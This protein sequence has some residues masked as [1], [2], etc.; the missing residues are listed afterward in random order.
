MKPEKVSV[1]CPRC[2]HTQQE[3]KAAFSS[4]CRKCGQYL[5][6]ED[7]LRTAA[8]PK[9]DERRA[10]GPGLRRVTCFTCG[11]ELQVSSTAQSTM[12]KRCSAH[13]DLRDYRI[14][15]A[16]S[17]N[18][19]TKGRF[20]VEEGA[21]LFNSESMAGDMVLKGRFLGKLTVENSLEIHPKAEIKGAFKA[22]RLVIC[23]G[24]RF[25]WPQTLQL[26]GADIAGEMVAD[27][28]ATST[29]VL[30]STARMFG[31]VRAPKM[32]VESGA[33]FVGNARIQ[34][35]EAPQQPALPPEWVSTPKQDPQPA[36]SRA[37][38]RTRKPKLLTAPPPHS[39]KN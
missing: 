36:S 21:F 29:V 27:I 31:D 16:V 25:R 22:G 39:G 34:E 6:I 30:R 10:E 4:A 26:A 24:S 19:K 37:S 7:V 1:T 12:C 20:V 32:L 14:T 13:V 2:G 35:S 38:P 9:A 18:F 11:T 5:R 3:P 15:N 33:V 17:K 8:A 23:E 28:E